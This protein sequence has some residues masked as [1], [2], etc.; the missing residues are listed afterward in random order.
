M[1]GRKTLL[2]GR[3]AARQLGRPAIVHFHDM[4]PLSGPMGTLQRRL[5]PWTAKALAVSAAVGEFV[6]REF[7]IPAERIEVLHNG[8]DIDRFQTPDG[9]ARARIRLEL[10]VDDARPVIGLV[11]RIITR[12]RGR[13]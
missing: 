6:N 5:A 13:T 2:A 1:E 3:L 9:D 8:L 10:G 4:L 11:G 7:A 12:S